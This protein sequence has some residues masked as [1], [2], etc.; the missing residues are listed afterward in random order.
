LA[1]G[2]IF[3]TTCPGMHAH[4]QNYQIM[5]ICSLSLD[6]VHVRYSVLMCACTWSSQTNASPLGICSTLACNYSL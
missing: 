6:I 2:D 1:P 4:V 3:S 5:A